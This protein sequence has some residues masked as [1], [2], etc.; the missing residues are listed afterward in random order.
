MAEKDVDEQFAAIMARWNDEGLGGD[1]YGDPQHDDDRAARGEEPAPDPEAGAGRRRTPSTP[2]TRSTRRRSP[3]PGRVCRCGP[4]R[5]RSRQ[6]RAEPPPKQERG[7]DDADADD[8]VR[9][10]LDDPEDDAHYSPPA[11]PRCP[12]RRTSTSGR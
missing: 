5:P 10:L 4:A 2:S 8:Q 6:D 12:R 7:P 11:P 1:P 9:G 3:A